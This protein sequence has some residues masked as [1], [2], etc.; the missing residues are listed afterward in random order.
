MF[1][2]IP[3][4]YNK[5]RCWEWGWPARGCCSRYHGRCTITKSN[6]LDCRLWKLLPAGKSGWGKDVRCQEG[7][8]RHEQAE[9]FLGLYYTQ[10]SG[11]LI[12]WDKF[13]HAKNFLSLEDDSTFTNTR[14]GG[15]GLA[16]SAKEIRIGVLIAARIMNLIYLSPRD[17]DKL[18]SPRFRVPKLIMS[19]TS[20]VAFGEKICSTSTRPWR[21]PKRS[22]KWWQ[23]SSLTWRRP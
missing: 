20:W 4:P 16:S 11:K 6:I 21:E 18:L 3:N 12:W 17:I 8:S 9:A 14:T 10:V 7:F 22:F 23:Q 19:C 15:G 2:G 5:N 1:I 13:L